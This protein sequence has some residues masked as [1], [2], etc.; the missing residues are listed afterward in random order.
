MDELVR[1]TIPLI[2]RGE[3]RPYHRPVGPIIGSFPRKRGPPFALLQQ[4]TEQ[5]FPLSRE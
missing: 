4:A 2:D 1:F 3:G 5:R